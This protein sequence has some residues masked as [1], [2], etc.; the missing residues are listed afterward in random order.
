ML[1]SEFQAACA[2]TNGAVSYIRPDGHEKKRSKLHRLSIM[3][4]QLTEHAVAV[5]CDQHGVEYE[6]PPPPNDLPKK[7]YRRLA[8][9]RLKLLGEKVLEQ[10]ELA[11]EPEFLRLLDGLPPRVRLMC[12][13]LRNDPDKIE[14]AK[15]VGRKA[16]EDWEKAGKPG[17][18]QN[19]D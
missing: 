1:E 7:A 5:A 8:D 11:S 12:E 6:P 14:E 15:Q 10:Q 9:R 4:R 17:V 13:V 19:L 16:V 2:Q 18:G 3:R